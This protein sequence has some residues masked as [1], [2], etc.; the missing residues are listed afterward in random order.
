MIKDKII[1]FLV[2]LFLPTVIYGDYELERQDIYD[3]K[4]FF[5]NLFPV[6]E[7]QINFESAENNKYWWPIGSENIV[8][9]NGTL[10]AIDAPENTVITSYFGYRDAVIDSSGTQISGNKAHGALDIA[11]S[12][13]VNVTNIIASQSGVVIYPTTNDIID[14]DD[15]GSYSCGGGYGNYVI[16]QHNDGNYTLYG[17]LAKNSITVRAGDSVKQ[18]QVIAK[19]GT[20]GNS[21]GPHLHFEVREGENNFSSRVDPLNYVDPDN[22]RPKASSG[23]YSDITKF[24]EYFEGHTTISGNNYVAENIGD[25]VT[26]I[27]PGVVWE[28]NMERFKRR[29]INNVSVGS[30]VAIDIVDDIKAEIIQEKSESIKAS[31]SSNGITLKPYQIDALVSRS[32]NT[33]NISGFYDAYKQYG[34]SDALYTNYMAE[35]VMAGSIFESGLRRR[36]EAE[37]NLFKTGNYAVGG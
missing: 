26:S 12:R 27:G 2:I 1:I 37:W 28:Y 13:G 31:L 34:E 17:H 19:M 20:S 16:I 36:R 3:Y 35:P 23:N 15:G 10:F 24:I 11:N 32:F 14:C 4:D 33:G 30:E 7:T 22:P 9:S 18:G 8:D 21:T 29:G 5:E 25:G 6:D